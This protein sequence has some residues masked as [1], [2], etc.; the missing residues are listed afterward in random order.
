VSFSNRKDF[1]KWFEK[2]AEESHHFLGVN[3]DGYRSAKQGANA[4]FD[5]FTRRI[6]EIEAQKLALYNEARELRD[7]LALAESALPYFANRG[8]NLAREVYLKMKTVFKSVKHGY[9]SAELW[10]VEKEFEV[11]DKEEPDAFP[12]SLII[13]PRDR[14]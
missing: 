2:W 13:W 9:M 12:Y 5:L 3:D 10:R 1:D 14:K 8:D 11:C 7:R 4:T 6:K